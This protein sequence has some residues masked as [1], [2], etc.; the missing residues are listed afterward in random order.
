MFFDSKNWLL[1]GSLLLFSQ[2]LRAQGQEGFPLSN[3]DTNANPCVNFYQYAAGGWMQNNPMPETESRWGSFNIL[4]KQNDVKIKVILEEA[5]KTPG[6]KGSQAQLVGDFYS[7][8]L[9]TLTLN[10]LGVKPLKAVLSKIN[11]LK[12]PQDVARLSAELRPLGVG[13]LF[14]FYVG[15]DAKDSETHRIHLGQGGLGL[16]DRDYYLQTDVNSVRIRQ[17][18]V[19]HIDAMFKL[20]GIKEARAGERLL[21][22]ETELAKISMS[23]VERRDPDKT[24]H[25]YSLTEFYNMPAWAGFPWKIFFTT[26]QLKPFDAVIVSQPAFLQGLTTLLSKYK[27]ADWKLYFKWQALNGSSNVLSGA[28]ERESFRFYQGVLSGT[29]VMK[30]RWERSVNLVNGT[31]GETL[32]Q[33]FVKKHFSPESKMKVSEM[34]ENL[35]EAFA[36]RIDALAWMSAATKKQAMVKLGAFN[37]KIGYPDKWKDYSMVDIKKNT[38]YQNVQNVNRR[39][40]QLMVD[41][42]GQPIDKD[43]WGMT[44]QTVNAY[45]SASRNE[46]VFPAG[47]LQPPFYDPEADDAVNYGGIGAVIGHEFSH[48]FDDKGSKFDAKGNL[49]NWWTAEDRAKFEAR[50]A[51]IVAQYSR[52]EVLDSV[53]VNG[54]LTQGE[55][56]ADLAGL[57]MAYYA[58]KASYSK[59]PAPE[60][61]GGFS[62]QQ[63]FFLGWT[64]VWSQNISEKELR[65]RILTD[66][67]APGKERVL[68]PLANMPEFW[69]A[70]GCTPGNPMIAPEDV[71]VVIW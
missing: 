13:G 5:A 23:R 30:P 65:R 12:S 2:G 43:E 29:K 31:L 71:R 16:P 46:I 61:I 7:S 50:T 54:A 44:P 49:K 39:K 1:A 57:T 22:M 33:L 9:D 14:S 52:F 40:F 24:Y 64:H 20:A 32:G 25:K 8:A 6:L 26:L 27:T 18:Y 34:V 48:G 11:G 10:K 58:L 69:E 3:L 66:S 51:K 28:I 59:K 17:E 56:I 62:W 53:Y 67:H 36:E 45:Y 68:G 63:R 47:I 60:P 70:F 15:I 42:I 37:Y 35:R 38:L 41:K 4:A 19:A 21:A 55:N